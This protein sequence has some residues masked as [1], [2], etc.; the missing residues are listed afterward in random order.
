[1]ALE[2]LSI[3]N[4]PSTHRVYAALFRDVSNSAFLQ[5]QLLSRNPEFEYAF[6]DASSIISRIHL[7]A[8]IFNAINT[9]TND[10]LKTPNV[11]SE[12]VLSLS[13]SNNIS[14]AYRRW[15]VT[16]DKT[17]GLI[18]VKI[19]VTAEEEEEITAKKVWE[20]LSQHVQG[21][22]I[23]L[24]DE[25]LSKATDWPKVKKYYKLNGVPVLDKFKDEDLKKK[26]MQ[27]LILMGM[28]VRGL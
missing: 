13:P 12:V 3:E 18:A 24:S 5:E 14:E 17:K 15:G 28:A 10:A 9:Q 21:T 16:P 2:R 25:E 11:H 6:L 27:N 1:M 8:A 26:Q 23:P 22:P 4:V 19:V 7:L 20:H